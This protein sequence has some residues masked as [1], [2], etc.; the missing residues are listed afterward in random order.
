MRKIAYIITLALALMAAAACHRRPLHDMEGKVLFKVTIDVDTVCNIG[1][2]IYNDKLAKPNTNT[3]ML[4]MF[5][6]DTKNHAYSGEALLSHKSYDDAGHQVFSEYMDIA[7]GQFDFVVYNFDTPNTIIKDVNN[8]NTIEACTE[9]LPQSVRSTII[10]KA[11]ESNEQMLSYQ[12][13]HL[14]VAREQNCYVPYHT[15]LQIIETTAHT[16]LNTYYIQIHVEGLR[17]VQ[18]AT[19]V[20]TGLYSANHFGRDAVSPYTLGER[21][22]NPATAV[23]FNME[24]STDDNIAGDNK[25]VLCALFNTF[26][27]IEDVSSDLYVTFNVVDIA[28]NKLQKTV[29]LDVVFLTE[30]ALERHWLLIDDVWVIDDPVPHEVG[31]GGFQPL[32]DDWDEEHGEIAL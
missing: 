9:E 10:G 30:D 7:S 25:D 20:V 8:E 31:G 12:P 26:G 2:Y 6:Y 24:K 1:R 19:A 23:Y 4:R 5:F 21:V 27:K 14:M 18:T 15:E 28:G 17:F 32:V 11:G 16:C 29:N 3:D 22:G 13:D